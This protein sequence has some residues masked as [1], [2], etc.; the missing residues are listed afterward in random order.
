MNNI[1]TPLQAF[2]AM[3]K[4][5][6]IYYKK[7]ASNDVG[8]LLSDMLFFHNGQTADP[9]AW[10]NWMNAIET[11]KDLTPL[12]GFISM[13]KYLHEYAECIS[14][15]DVKSLLDE[16]KLLPNGTTVNPLYWHNWM[17][18]VDAVS[19]NIGDSRSYL[20]LKK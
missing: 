18:C 13:T 6:E 19:K 14:S 1:L 7:T 8:A 9:A 5:L 12:Q 11:G 15:R 17:T 4:F 10:Y 16:M 2:N 3:V 20:E